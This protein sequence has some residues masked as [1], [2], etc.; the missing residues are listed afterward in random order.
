MRA[1]EALNETTGVRKTRN[2]NILVQLK[3]GMS[4]IDIAGKIRTL[5]DSKV[6]P[7]PLQNMVSTEIK[8]IDP[9]IDTEELK[10]DINRDLKIDNASCV[11]IK[12][13]RPNL[14]E[15]NRP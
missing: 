6:M 9:L 10:K 2:G 12:T 4:A 1:K 11:E 8:N 5:I 7:K 15:R 13:L 14:G 3:A